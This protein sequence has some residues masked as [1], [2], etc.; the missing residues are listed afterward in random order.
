MI[1]LF[2]AQPVKCYSQLTLI[3]SGCRLS[4]VSTLSSEFWAFLKQSARPINFGHKGC[5]QSWNKRAFFDQLTPDG[6][7]RGE[8]CLFL[9]LNHNSTT[10]FIPFS[11]ICHQILFALTEKVGKS[12]YWFCYVLYIHMDLETSYRLQSWRSRGYDEHK[13]FVAKCGLNESES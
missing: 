3:S 9:R 13:I 5:L 6:R 2:D 7:K 4:R 8:T 12:V 1:A 10:S 11:D